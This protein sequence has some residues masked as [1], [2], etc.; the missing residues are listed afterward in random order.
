MHAGDY[1]KDFIATVH[2]GKWEY[3]TDNLFSSFDL[4]LRQSDACVFYGFSLAQ[5]VKIDISS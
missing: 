4:S 1:T 3:F 2:K 5:C